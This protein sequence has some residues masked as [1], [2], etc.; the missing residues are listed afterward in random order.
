MTVIVVP[1]HFYSFTDKMLVKPELHAWLDQQYP[2]QY[3]ITMM[4][5]LHNFSSK[6]MILLDLPCEQAISEFNLTWLL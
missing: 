4:M 6:C 5:G 3:K 2:D 1:E